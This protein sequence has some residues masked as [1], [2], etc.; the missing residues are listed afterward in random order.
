MQADEGVVRDAV[1][2][3]GGQREA[4]EEGGEDGRGQ[5]LGVGAELDEAA[6]VGD[7]G[8]GIVAY[9]SKGGLVCW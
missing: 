5:V 6:E 1:V 9:G 8:G 3:E 2:G 4:F 7:E